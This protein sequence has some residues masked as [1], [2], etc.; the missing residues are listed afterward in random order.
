M[1]VCLDV[2]E[3]GLLWLRGLRKLKIGVINIATVFREDEYSLSLL[4]VI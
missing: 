2:R 3:G 1:D 4:V